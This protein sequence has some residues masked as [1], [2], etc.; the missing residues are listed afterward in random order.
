[1]LAKLKSAETLRDKTQNENNVLNHVVLSADTWTTQGRSR[2]TNSKVELAEIRC[3][4]AII[5]AS[6]VKQMDPTGFLKA[7]SARARGLTLTGHQVPSP[8]AGVTAAVAYL[9]NHLEPAEASSLASG[10]DVTDNAIIRAK[11]EAT[12]LGTSAFDGHLYDKV[13]GWEESYDYAKWKYTKR[14]LTRAEREASNMGMHKSV[15]IRRNPPKYLGIAS[16]KNLAS[17][18]AAFARAPQE[19]YEYTPPKDEQ[20]Y[21]FDKIDI[22]KRKELWRQSTLE[23]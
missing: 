22:E 9:L 12:V 3:R 4:E 5:L 6:R 13:A 23:I 8:S 14:Y 1:M 16:D 2:T 15:A 7:C 20:P 18:K 19:N 17:A 10:I 21:R 11:N